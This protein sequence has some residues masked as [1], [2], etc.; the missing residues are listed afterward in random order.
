MRRCK[1]G[2][3]AKNSDKPRLYL[4]VDVGGTKILCAWWRSRAACCSGTARPRR[5]VRKAGAVLKTIRRAMEEV[6][7]RGGRAAVGPDGRRHRDPG[8]G[9]SRRGPRGR[10]AQHEPLG[11][12]G[13]PQDEVVVPRAGG[14]GQR[15]QPGHAGR[16]LDRG[17]PRGLQRLRHLR[18]DGHRRRLRPERPAV[19]RLPGVGR[20]GRPH[21]HADRRAAAAAAATAAAWRPWPAAPPSSATSARPSRPAARPS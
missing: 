15:R 19:A 14:G 12:G 8:R 5:A 13:G 3:M 6:L 7:A 2:T 1:G 18:R 17:R 9:R 11:R 10:D 16:A 21:H 20:R 4:G